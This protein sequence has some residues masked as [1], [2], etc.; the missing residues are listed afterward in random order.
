MS[1]GLRDQIEKEI[2]GYI[3]ANTETKLKLPAGFR[4]RSRGLPIWV[5]GTEP[6]LRFNDLGFEIYSK[7]HTPQVLDFKIALSSRRMLE[8]VRAMNNR[9]WYY[10][11]KFNN[12]SHAML[13]IVHCWDDDLRI[14]WV[15]SGRDWDTWVRICS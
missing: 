1:F 3:E 11:R 14:N 15:L 10:S 8:L 4:S 12:Q 5:Q 7:M 9:P 13:H 2:C 6:N